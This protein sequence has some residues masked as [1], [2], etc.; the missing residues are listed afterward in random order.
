MWI[1]DSPILHI[2]KHKICRS[3]D[4]NL[5]LFFCL[6]ESNLGRTIG[7]SSFRL[8]LCS[9]KLAGILD[10][11]FRKPS[12]DKFVDND[13]I[14]AVWRRALEAKSGIYDRF[15][16]ELDISSSVNDRNCASW[17]VGDQLVEG[18]SRCLWVLINQECGESF[19]N[20]YVWNEESFDIQCL[21]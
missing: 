19:W 5:T 10:T 1:F 13:N 2:R 14:R 4:R 11:S 12:F 15:S 6:L 17:G 16:G 20:W 21:R 18:W 8:Q 7:L 9:M 3:K